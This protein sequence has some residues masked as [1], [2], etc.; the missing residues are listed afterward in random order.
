MG[1]YDSGVVCEGPCS[2]PLL[3]LMRSGSSRTCPHVPPLL[4]FLSTS[5][6]EISHALGALHLWY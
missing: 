1:V 3:G 2:R 5:R 6:I 4:D